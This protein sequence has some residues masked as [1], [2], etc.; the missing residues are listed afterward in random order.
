M[1]HALAAM[2]A[3]HN[4]LPVIYQI[5]FFVTILISLF[6]YS[7]QMNYPFSIRF[8]TSLG[9]EILNSENIYQSV[10]ILPTTV[11]TRF[12][13][14]LHIEKLNERKQ[15]MLILKDGM[16]QGDYRKLVIRLRIS[17]LE[18]D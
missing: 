8:T 6:F 16:K 7:R 5:V 4:S 17:G 10:K 18:M 13:S 3:L 1:I 11:L 14:I 2:A 15:T 12:F 9:W